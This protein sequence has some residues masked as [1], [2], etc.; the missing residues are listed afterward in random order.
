MAEITGPADVLVIFGITGDLA[1]KMTFVSLY[2]L[3]RRGELSCPIVGVAIDDLT[4]D[5]LRDRA[6]SAIDGAGESVDDAVF[7]RLAARLTYVSGDYADAATY[8]RLAAHVADANRPTF[9]LE[10][11]PSLFARVVEGLHGAGL[12]ATARIVIEKPFG[13]DL[14]SARELNA[15]LRT[16]VDESQL[17]RIDHFSGKEPVLDILFLRF[18]NAIFEPLWN[19][20]YVG[21]VQITMAEDFG[22]DDRGS[23]Y[24]PVGALRDVVQNHLL[25]VL[26]LVAMEPPSDVGTET[27]RSKKEEV[28]RAIPDADPAHYVRGQYDG[29]LDVSGVAKGSQTE[30]YAA[31]ALHIEN[32]RWAG[33]PFFLRAGKAMTTRATEVRVIFR[34]AP[35]FSALHALA[36][37]APNELIVR[38]DPDPGARLM[39]HAKKPGKPAVDD[40][41]LDLL[42]SQ[43][44]G[45]MP[46]PY[47]RLLS[48]AMAGEGRLFTREDSVE[49][50]WRIVQPL[51]DAAPPVIPYAK[52]TMG[53]AEA[54]ALV[55]GHTPWQSP[56]LGR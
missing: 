24:D 28:F 56:W 30:T 38:I 12:T 44:E 15:T 48:D 37:V 33:V 26:A 40:V 10:I 55:K 22:V 6:R 54:D 20:N 41:G 5:Q 51:L 45:E 52:G 46:T 32:W 13:H 18:T 8:E 7:G 2:R 43:Q 47:E 25:Q 42:F 1:K 29:Y 4:D 21:S 14:A 27:L 49:E 11:P 19:R 39:V 35:M 3:E 31:M 50:T 53:P 23:F 17:F 16:L 34:R 36:H 9:Y